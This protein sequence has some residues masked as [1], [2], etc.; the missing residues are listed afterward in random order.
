MLALHPW[1]L[2][3][4]IAGADTTIPASDV[5]RLLEA[6]R[7]ASYRASIWPGWE[8]TAMPILLV[9]ADTEFLIGTGA[10]G[11][12]FV[13]TTPS[14]YLGGTL[15]RRDRTLDPAL[16]ATFPVAGVPTV[17]I[18][19]AGRTRRS[20]GEW[21]VT[22]LHEHFH[23]YQYGSPGYFDGVRALD[24]SRG[25]E[26][27][28]WML[29]FPFPYDAAAV[30]SAADSVKR[31]LLAFVD[32]PVPAA[33]HARAVCGAMGALQAQLSPAERRYLQFQLWQEGV[34][35]Y[36]ELR[37]ANAAAEAEPAPAFQALPDAV[38][39][40]VLGASLRASLRKELAAPF[41]ALDRVNFYSMGAALALLLD[42]VSPGWKA[43]Y[44]DSRF[45]LDTL[46]D[47]H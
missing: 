26:T 25:D 2:L 22:V 21:V 31:A 29:N 23:Q 14:P 30:A 4:T 12:G 47:C 18:G 42:Q 6:R 39:W 40:A 27:G 37:V 15:L 3:V 9:T 10:P 36:I 7:L 5:T 46:L 32:D 45:R 43:R 19:Q 38:A 20:S 34:P 17:V 1:A 11:N 33:A 13:A 35:R 28:M 16:L 24:L 44:H 41:A 8:H